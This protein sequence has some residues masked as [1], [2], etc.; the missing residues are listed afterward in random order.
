MIPN[1][2]RKRIVDE[3]NIVEV[4]SRYVKLEKK[5]SSYFGICPFHDDT[6]PSMSVSNKVKMFN[7]WSC[8]T[9]G[10]VIYFV[11]RIENITMD[12]AAIKLA[13]EI[14]LKIDQT[15]SKE[16][17]KYSRLTKMMDDAKEFYKFYL[18]NSEEG[19]SAIEYLHKRG[20]EDEVINTFEIGLAPDIKDALTTYLT[21]KNYTELDQIEVGLLSNE[22]TPHDMFRKR[23]MFPL[24]NPQGKTIGFSGR[25]YNT[26]TKQGKYIN[27]SDNFIFH[28]S[29]VLYN[30]HNAFNEI[31]RK[32]TVI[33]FEGFMDV[34]AAYRAGIGYGIATMGTALTTE[35]V[36][37]ILSL[38]KNVVLCFDGDAAGVLAM[39]RAA[40]MFAET[41]NIVSSVVLPNNQDPDE[42]IKEFGAAA[43]YNYLT[44][45]V[46]PVFEWLYIL[47]KKNLIVNDI[48]S[49]NKFKNEVFNFL[50][51]S[52][53]Q[54]VIDFY[55]NKMAADLNMEYENLRRDFNKVSYNKQ[56]VNDNN[57][58]EK[59]AKKEEIV[60]Q[61]QLRIPTNV[62]K[63]YEVI[64]KHSIYQEDALKEYL[65][66]T[67]NEF[68]DNRLL[69]EYSILSKIVNIYYE[70][71]NLDRE[72][73]REDIIINELI[74]DPSMKDKVEAILNDDLISKDNRDDFRQCLNTVVRF[75]K[76]LNSRRQLARYQ[77]GD[78]EAL[79]DFLDA[80]KEECKP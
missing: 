56:F 34:I 28:K 10:N 45:Q 73:D 9:K 30:L 40:G 78:K 24:A 35:H 50:I 41:G 26:D 76:N 18:H 25:L 64:I 71:P 20:I 1:N 66:A 37:Q 65:S 4:V 43:L 80:K 21:K 22:G 13:G 75:L 53:Q 44:E 5:G 55:L 57:Y 12:Q 47:K 36:K 49:V 70:R 51:A 15:V 63:A 8:H 29:N 14:G 79:N 11:S 74:K 16:D 61:K 69:N 58:Q 31:R 17:E 67:N 2:I 39:E 77:K 27:S 38:T 19:L 23:I 33:L 62:F 59:E 52:K 48:M 3:T 42:Y 7:C 60:V 68:I 6:N 46:K 72:I 32:D 54:S